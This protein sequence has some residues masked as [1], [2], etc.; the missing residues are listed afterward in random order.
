MDRIAP[1]LRP[2]RGAGQ[3]HSAFRSASGRRIVR[4]VTGK[5]H[6]PR[7]TTSGAKIAAWW[8]RFQ[9]VVG[10]VPLLRAGVARV[11]APGG[12]GDLLAWCEIVVATVLLVIFVRDLRAE[13]RAQLAKE[14]PRSA[15]CARGPRVVRCCRRGA[16]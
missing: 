8:Q 2:V 9:H 14:E 16:V 10:G 11:R 15:P 13:A 6:D 3:P 5:R 7:W 4:D 12:H 1:E